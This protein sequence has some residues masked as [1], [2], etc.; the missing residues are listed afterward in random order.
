MKNK[1]GHLIF[2]VQYVVQKLDGWSSYFQFDDGDFKMAYTV[3]ILLFK[4]DF[5]N[6]TSTGH[7]AVLE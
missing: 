5:V 6:R 1:I 7:C 3:W 4:F 2:I